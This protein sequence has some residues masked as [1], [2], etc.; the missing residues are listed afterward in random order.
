MAMFLRLRYYQSTQ[1]RDA[2]TFVSGQVDRAQA[3]PSV[4]EP[5]KRGLGIA[6][7]LV[8]IIVA[9]DSKPD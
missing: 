6:R 1:T 5:V 4:P 3:H 2:F 8:R 7:D 9:V